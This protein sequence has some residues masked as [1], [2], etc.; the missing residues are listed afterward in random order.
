MLKTLLAIEWH[1]VSVAETAQQLDTSLDRGQRKGIT[2]LKR[3]FSE[4][5]AIR[6][7]TQAFLDRAEHLVHGFAP[8]SWF[9]TP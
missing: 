1:V 9:F 5:G 4:P 6:K 2:N 7:V 8:L 3:L